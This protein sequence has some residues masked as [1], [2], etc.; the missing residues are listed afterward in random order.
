[1]PRL[2]GCGLGYGTQIRQGEQ[3]FSPHGRR[4]PQF[5]QVVC[6]FV[7]MFLIY[8]LVFLSRSATDYLF[9]Q[10]SEIPSVSLAINIIQLSAT[11]RIACPK[12]I[13]ICKIR[14]YHN[15]Y[16]C[17]IQSLCDPGFET[18]ETN[19]LRVLN[20]SHNGARTQLNTTQFSKPSVISSLPFTTPLPFACGCECSISR[21]YHP[22]TQ[23]WVSTTT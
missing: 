10:K 11:S 2:E 23:S 6:I 13:T 20:L 5:S 3:F 9:P 14:R 16:I 15:Y 1:M 19:S 8:L 7:F 12:S 18:C 22:L 4:R 17:H 21:M